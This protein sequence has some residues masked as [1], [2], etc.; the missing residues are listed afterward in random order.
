[1]VIVPAAVLEDVRSWNKIMGT[2]ASNKILGFIVG[3][4]LHLRLRQHQQRLLRPAHYRVRKVRK[5][6]WRRTV[7]AGAGRVELQRGS[8]RRR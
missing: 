1:M 6:L 8:Q 2:S 4:V 3:E 5:V 7:L